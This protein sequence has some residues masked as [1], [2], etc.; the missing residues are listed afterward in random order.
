V[1]VFS[2]TQV[3]TLL[4]HDLSWKGAGESVLVFWLVWWGWTQFTW[5]LNAANT[6]HHHVELGTLLA[7]ALA[8]F[9]AIA[10]PDAFHGRGQW[11]ALPY[12]TV[13]ALGLTLYA[14]VAWQN[15]AQKAAVRTFSLVSTGGLAAVVLGGFLGGSAQIAIWG[16]AILLDVLAAVVGGKIE[17][18]NLYAGHFCERHGLFV[19]IALGETLIVAAVGL[20]GSSWTPPLLTAA[21]LA[22]A[23]SCALWWSY[24]AELKQHLEHGLA[25]ARGAAQSTMA[26]DAFSL[27]HFPMLCGIIAYAVVTEETVTH[28]TQPLSAAA[29]LALALGLLCF[30][31]GA[32]TALHRTTGHFLWFRFSVSLATAAAVWFAGDMVPQVSLG[33]A[34]AGT[35]L[36]AAVEQRRSLALPPA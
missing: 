1:F 24:F 5:A 26:R 6:T 16:L 14:W 35:A 2:V 22:V 17:G 4:H 8:F 20:T 32:G 12:V 23:V 19:I 18:W 3:V 9:M 29:R 13:R 25:S 28:P 7:T 10:I 27:F 31:G 34:F 15:P 30:L 21:V 11:F 33:I 36:I